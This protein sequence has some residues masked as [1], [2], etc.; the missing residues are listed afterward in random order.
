MKSSFGPLLLAALIL[1]VPA[2][3]AASTFSLDA[4]VLGYVFDQDTGELRRMDGFLG[5][6][7]L[8]APIDLG[9]PI[10]QA[11][12]APDQKSAIVQDDQ[13]R[14][15][16]VNLAVT[17]PSAVALEGA[18]AADRAMFSPSGRRAALYSSATGRLQ[19]LEVLNGS[20][21]LGDEVDSL[22]SIGG[23]AGFALSD[24]GT[25]LAASMSEVGGAL[26]MLKPDALPLR[27]SSLESLGGLAFFSRS[28]DAVAADAGAN[29]VLLLRSGAGSWHASPVATVNDFVENP[30][31]VQVTADGRFVA[32]AIAG[33][34]TSIPL[35]GGVAQFTDCACAPRALA[36]LAGGNTFLL[37]DDTSSPLQVVEVGDSSRVL[38]VP[39]IP[40]E[41]E[42][43]S[44]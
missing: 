16:L 21:R 14:M 3:S 41:I 40:Q 36:P 44:Q 1:L 4:P 43:I 15:L 25:V 37:T 28:D 35:A 32:L 11:V 31:A 9:F 13:G 8:G 29:E 18:M 5:A 19:L 2:H 23:W 12:V 42:E 30:F 6:S 26:Y 38:F 22:E 10:M 27:V 34:V 20:A 7:S 39:A 33:G 17:P 24:S